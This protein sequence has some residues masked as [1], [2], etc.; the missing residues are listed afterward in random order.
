[1]AKIY[2]EIAASA[3]MTFDKSFARSNGQPLDSTEIY[4]SKVA[5]EAYAAGD[6][7]YVGQ[8]IAV[9]EN[10][11]LTHYGIEPDNSLKEL[12]S[13]PVGDESTIV[14]AEDGTVSLAGISGLEFIE[15]NESGEQVAVTYQPLLTSA[16][17][18]WV[19]PSATTVEGLATEIEGLKTRMA[20]V[21][22]VVGNTESGL[23]RDVADLKAVAHKHENAGVLADISAEKV[24]AWDG[25][26]AAAEK[27]AK[28]YADS[29]N[30][31]MDTRVKAIEDDYLKADD[32]YDDTALAGRVK[33]IEDD[34]LKESDKTALKD[35]LT[36][37]I[38]TAKSEA[39]A[40][41]VEAIMGEAGIDAKYDTLKE[42]ADWIL[43]DTTNSAA[44]IT[45][46]SDIEKDYLKGADK[47]E[48]QGAI[49][50]L[51]ALVGTL[52][53]GSAS[54]TV[55]EYINEVVNALSIGDYAKA[56]ELTA[57][58]GRVAALEEVGA[59]KN[60]IAEVDETQFAI[61]AGR[62]LTLLDVAIGKVTGL[63]DALNGKADKGTTLADYGITDAYTKEETLGK[64]EEKITEIN[65]GESAGEVLSQ[66][67]SYKEIN[68]AAVEAIE[69]KLGT[70]AEGAQVNVIDD[71][72]EA[73][74]TIAEGKKLVL[75]TV[76][77]DQVAGLP[78]A[79]SNKVE[80]VEG[81]QLS[82]EDFT[83]EMKAKLE[84]LNSAANENVIELIKAGGVALP[85]KD[86]TV[87]IP[88]A[89]K[90]ALGLVKGSEGLNM[91]VVKEDFTME[92]HSLSVSKLVQ[93]EG[94]TLILNGG[95]AAG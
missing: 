6:V 63:S 88:G 74:F 28:E 49:N 75:R 95:N 31:V 52:P 36:E 61:D 17:L 67:N 7:A 4:Y 73:N 82:A 24:A 22:G 55:V 25:A 54:A 86:K 12:G 46:V 48:L 89:T 92:V 47:T 79:L 64:I 13:S 23:V 42:I 62:K 40:D 50:D 65:G 34:Y 41:A 15:E 30:A 78:T 66:L 21:E 68:D 87:D 33:T 1:M 70:V 60:V 38:A 2:G 3:L 51:A 19:K 53:E 18:T 9:I 20:A 43:A 14:V 32:K 11:K 76:S 58:A 91:V 10:G 69:T 93:E 16:G 77:M 80:I 59:E 8:K 35:E 5:A 44:L 81:K 26:Q 45:R 84:G 37:A 39:T 90:E 83:T 72:D 85:V 71:V 27:T 29:L 57:L 56:S 94:D